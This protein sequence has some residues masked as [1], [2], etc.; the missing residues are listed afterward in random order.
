MIDEENGLRELFATRREDAAISNPY[1][2]LVNVHGEM[3][4]FRYA[5]ETPE[6]A[7][8]PK[9]L[10]RDRVA[11]V[12]GE[13]SVVDAAT[14]ASRWEAFSKGG[15][16][17]MNWNNMFV[18]GG[19][20]LSN[21]QVA[22]SPG[23]QGSDIDI[24]LYGLPT[25]AAANAKLREIHATIQA[26]SGAN[27][28]VIRTHRAVT[29]IGEYPFRHI[30]IILKVYKSPAE[31]LLGFDVDSCCVGYDGTSVWTA[32]RARRALNKGYNLVNMTRRSLTYETRL[33][34]Y[35]KRGYAVA[36]PN[37][38]KARVDP[39]ILTRSEKNAQGLAKLLIY[40]YQSRHGSFRTRQ[41]FKDAV[42]LCSLLDRSAHGREGEGGARDL[43]RAIASEAGRSFLGVFL[44]S[45]QKARGGAK[46]EERF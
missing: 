30:Q 17:G 3:D 32:K 44:A 8:V 46:R 5:A 21:V 15:L 25:D 2:G 6:E 36:V 34:K 42:R 18:A 22:P 16:K 9:L 26:N 24:F 29:I 23:A 43:R 4:T 1:V 35:A 39:N 27:C 20:V 45:G 40:E 33:K 7:A 14:F 37:L 28:D 31:V 10:T 38:D 13:S 12:P 41:V 19:A 11:I